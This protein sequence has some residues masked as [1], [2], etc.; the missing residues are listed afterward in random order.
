MSSKTLSPET[1]NVPTPEQAADASLVAR[2]VLELVKAWAR[3]KN[4]QSAS[5][6]EIHL[7]GRRF[8]PERQ[9]PLTRTLI[10]AGLR[11]LVDGTYPGLTGTGISI[12][13]IR[14][15]VELSGD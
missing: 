6:S 14:P 4:V 15:E 3:Y 13:N 8:A 2:Y 10:H 9:T 1:I 12:N 7:A 5:A 11:S